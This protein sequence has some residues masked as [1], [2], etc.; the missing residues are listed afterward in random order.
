MKIKY[1]LNRTLSI[2]N[3]YI[4]F[5]VIGMIMLVT[6]YFSYAIF[7][8][9][10]ESKG[11]LNIVTGNLYGLIES[12]DLTHNKT[13]TVAAGESKTVTLVHKNVNGISAKLNLYYSSTSNNI[14][15]GYLAS[16]DS[17][18]TTS[19]YVLAKNGEANDSKTIY[20]RI[21]NTGETEATVTFGTNAGLAGATLAFPTGKSALQQMVGTIK[22]NNIVTAYQYDENTTSPTFCLGGDETTCQETTCYEDTTEGS[23]PAGT[24]IKYHVNDT[25]DKYFNVL[26]DKGNSL[27]MQQRENTV[28]STAWYA[29]SDDNTKGPTTILPALET[30]TNGWTNVNPLTYTAGVTEFGTGD[31]KTANTACTGTEGATPNSTLCSDKTYPDFTK[32]NVKARM[33]TAQEAGEMG[34]RMYKSDGSSERSCKKFMSNYLNISTSYG[35]TV[36]DYIG[37]NNDNNHGYWTASSNSSGLTLALGVHR[38]GRIDLNDN[39]S[40][41]WYGA[42]AVVEIDKKF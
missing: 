31:Y 26:Y 17:A 23:C 5:I 33:I 2:K 12:S 38:S 35:G 37:T 18:P 19:G 32:T 10:N 9:H 22:N 34:C 40:H 7:T 28:Y 29:D 13:V 14:N 41:V 21:T 3:S 36:N 30:A 11:A 20:V 27:T 4:A 1:F 15:I 16:G 39:T 24:I 42:R 6:G 25:D 8:A